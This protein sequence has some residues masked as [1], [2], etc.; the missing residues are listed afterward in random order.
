MAML[1][2]IVNFLANEVIGPRL[3]NSKVFQSAAVKTHQQVLRSQDIAKQSGEMLA[4]QKA[5][6]QQKSSHFWSEFKD[7][8]INKK[9]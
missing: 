8:L 3:A 7:E 2:R 4:K 6:T 9:K 5:N 1:Q